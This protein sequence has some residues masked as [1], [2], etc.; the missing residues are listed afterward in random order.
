LEGRQADVI[1]RLRTHADAGALLRA[2]ERW[3]HGRREG[4]IDA[5]SEAAALLEPYRRA[6]AIPDV[7]GAA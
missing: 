7:G 6:P 2:V 4:E 1:P 3:L 5:R